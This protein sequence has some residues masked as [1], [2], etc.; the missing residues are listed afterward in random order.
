MKGFTSTL[1]LQGLGFKANAVSSNKLEL[2]LGFS[3][4]KSVD[5]PENMEVDIKKGDINFIS[6]DLQKMQSFIHFLTTLKK[7]DPYKN[8]GFLMEGRVMRLKESKKNK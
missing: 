2:H 1:K 3:H 5:I 8:K 4:L 6:P 7:F